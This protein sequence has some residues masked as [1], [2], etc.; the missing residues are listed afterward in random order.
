M[1]C[2]EVVICIVCK[3]WQKGKLTAKEALKNLGE[4]INS[5]DDSSHY[6][7]VVEKILDEEVPMSEKN[8][9]LDKK[10]QER[11]TKE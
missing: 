1:I 6:Y 9:E 3:D 11:N 2:K 7:E 10:W 4:M 8:E 5:E